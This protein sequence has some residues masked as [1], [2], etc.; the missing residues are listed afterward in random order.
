M[1]IK[2]VIQKNDKYLGA[3]SHFCYFQFYLF[4]LDPSTL[5]VLPDPELI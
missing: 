2:S 3:E 1:L 5:F 4:Q